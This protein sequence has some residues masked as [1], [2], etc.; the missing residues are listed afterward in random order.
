MKNIVLLFLIF[1]TLTSCRKNREPDLA[2]KFVGDFYGSKKDSNV[3]TTE[4]WKITKQDLNHVNVIF[5]F[6]NT[7]PD[8]SITRSKYDI[9]IPNVTVSDNNVLDFNNLFVTNQLDYS[10]IGKAKL[11][12]NTLDYDITIKSEYNTSKLNNKIY[13]R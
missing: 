4:T 5:F 13:R 11:I 9:Y 12:D 2:G 6:T 1:C 7:Y 3:N 10:V 8:G